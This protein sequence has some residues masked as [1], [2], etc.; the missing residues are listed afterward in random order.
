MLL[1]KIAFTVLLSATSVLGLNVKQPHLALTSSHKKPLALSPINQDFEKVLQPVIID[2]ANETI[3]LTFSIDTEEKPQ[4]ATLLLGS[5]SRGVETHIEPLIK[6]V[7]SES[8]YKFEIAIEKLP[9]P[10][11]YLGIKS[12]EPLTASLILASENALAHNIFVELFDL[13]LI[14]DTEEKLSWPSRLGAQPE[15]THIFRSTPKTVSPL[16]A[17]FTSVIIAGFFLA[18]LVAWTYLGTFSRVN[19]TSYGGAIFHLIAFVG[20]V[21]GMEYVFT[22]YYLGASI[23]DTLGHGFYVSLGGLFFGGKLLK[24][25]SI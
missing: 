25:L 14:F 24:S 17:Q 20:C 2:R 8:T 3:E 18:L 10:L 6:N 1:S 12:R 22:R 16:I 21:L 23:F 9:E 5:I 19:F 11:L 15:I 7:D 13:D 4:Q